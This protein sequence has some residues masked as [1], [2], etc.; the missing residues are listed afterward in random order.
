MGMY[1]GAVGSVMAGTLPDNAGRWQWQP[2]T[3]A[4]DPD[5]IIRLEQGA[6]SEDVAMAATAALAF[7]GTEAIGAA[8]TMATSAA[9]NF[10]AGKIVGDTFAMDAIAALAFANTL[11]NLYDDAF[12]MNATAALAVLGVPNFAAAV[13]MAATAQFDTVAQLNAA[14]D[15][16][17]NASAALTM[18]VVRLV[19]E[20]VAMSASATWGLQQGGYDVDFSMNTLASLQIRGIVG[21]IPESVI[22]EG[23][24]LA[25][26]RLFT[27]SI[28]EPKL[29]DVQLSS[30]S[31]LNVS[32]T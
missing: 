5:N 14:G 11:G 6:Y 9:L 32:L 16:T 27:Q 2:T 25:Q 28:A 1:F 13:A 21:L 17:M 24:A 20:T 12:A 8:V 26:A 18:S 31:L 30:P 15:L 4:H 29:T 23:V 7:A 19:V 3:A 10:G 22:I